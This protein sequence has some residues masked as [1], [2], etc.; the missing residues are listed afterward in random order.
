[1]TPPVAAQGIGQGLSSRRWDQAPALRCLDK[2]AQYLGNLRRIG[3]ERYELHLGSTPR[4]DQ[5]SAS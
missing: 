3:D 4:A 2:M 1:M 5:G